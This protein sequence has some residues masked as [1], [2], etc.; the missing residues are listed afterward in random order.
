MKQMERGISRNKGQPG[1]AQRR[2][3]HEHERRRRQRELA[4]NDTR[5]LLSVADAA[6]R[7]GCSRW[8][9]YRLIQAGELRSVT[10]GKTLKVHPID[11][12]DYLLGTA[13]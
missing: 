2:S 10:V 6:K 3:K 8:T 11:L 4:L 13:S 12:D 9:A 1:A 5:P 7:L